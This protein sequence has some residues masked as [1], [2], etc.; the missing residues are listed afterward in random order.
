MIMTSPRLVWGIEAG[1]F[2][3]L[4]RQLRVANPLEYMPPELIVITRGLSPSPAGAAEAR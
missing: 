2:V 1:W 4:L 3:V